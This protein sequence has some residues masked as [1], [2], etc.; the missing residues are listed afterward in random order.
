MIFSQKIV[1]SNRSN[2]SG[3]ADEKLALACIFQI[4]MV[5]FLMD[6]YSLFYLV[7]ELSLICLLLLSAGT[8]VEIDIYTENSSIAVLHTMGVVRRFFVP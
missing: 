7:S 3:N 5:H 8:G 6:V 4:Y 1:F 2:L